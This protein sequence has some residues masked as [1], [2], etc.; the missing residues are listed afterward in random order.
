MR[1][2]GARRAGALREQGVDTVTI[3]G[4]MTHMC[5]DTTARQAGHRGFT[6]EFL[7]DANT[8]N[9]AGQDLYDAWFA[10]GKSAPVVMAAMDGPSTV[11]TGRMAFLS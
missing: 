1:K 6:V 7:R 11:I 10:S 9:S 5:C 8:T 2:L 3:A 4:Y